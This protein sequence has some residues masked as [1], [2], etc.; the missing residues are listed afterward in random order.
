MRVFTSFFLLLVGVLPSAHADIILEEVD[1]TT[2]QVELV[3]QVLDQVQSLDS[4]LPDPTNETITRDDPMPRSR[5]KPYSFLQLT[6]AQLAGTSHP[7]V[8][9]GAVGLIALGANFGVKKDDARFAASIGL[10]AGLQTYMISYLA[11][12]GFVD[13]LANPRFGVSLN[14]EK[15]FIYVSG[16]FFIVRNRNNGVY[17]EGSTDPNYP[18]GN[19]VKLEHSKGIEIGAFLHELAA[20]DFPA[21]IGLFYEQSKNGYTQGGTSRSYSMKGIRLTILFR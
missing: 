17:N 8:N 13:R 4:S 7:N 15:S 16:R 9:G 3:R 20:I 10:D 19:F 1:P 2:E 14:V 6:P 12:G 5:L 11:S 21:K 18:E